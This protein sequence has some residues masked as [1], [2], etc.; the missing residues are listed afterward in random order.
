MNLLQKEKDSSCAPPSPPN[1]DFPSPKGE[2]FAIIFPKP[3]DNFRT[4]LYNKDK[5]NK[6]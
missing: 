6:L 3:L 2:E 4:I 1:G 5:E